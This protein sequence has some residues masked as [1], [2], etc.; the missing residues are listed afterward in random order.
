MRVVSGAGKAL[1][2]VFWAIA[3]LNLTTPFAHPFAS[4]IGL[5]AVAVLVVHILELLMFRRR[6][7]ALPRPRVARLQVLL[8]GVFHLLTLPAGGSGAAVTDVGVQH[9]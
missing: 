4:L 5:A 6:L 7:S 3:G 1:M 2:M 9:A 8:F